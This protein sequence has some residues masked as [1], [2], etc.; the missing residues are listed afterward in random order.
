MI[1]VSAEQLNVILNIL[2]QHVPGYEVRAFGSRHNWTAK[3]YSDLDLAVVGETKLDWKIISNLK[4]AFEESD[5]P[6][7]VDVLDWHAIPPKF[8]DVI[9][10]GFEVIQKRLP[11]RGRTRAEGLDVRDKG[12]KKYIF[13]DFVNINPIVK[14]NSAEQNLLGTSGRQR[15]NREAFDN[16]ELKLPPLPTQ[17][18]IA[19]ILSALDDKIELNCQT[20]QTLE[21][22]AQAIFKEWFVDFR[23]PGSTGEMQDSEL[24]P[25][26]KGWR[27]K[28]LYDTA[29]FVNGSAFR[30]IDFSSNHSGLPIIK[31]T[32]LKNGISNQTK[33]TEKACEKKYKIRNGEILFSWSGSPDTSIDTFIWTS[34]PAWLNQHIF[35]VIPHCP[36]EKDFIYHLLRFLKPIF[37]EI[38]RDKQ[39]TGLGHVTVQDMKRMQVVY[40]PDSIIHAFQITAAAFLEK[41]I[42]NSQ[43][44]AT[45]AVIRDE[46]LP[47]LINEE[48]RIETKEALL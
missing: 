23:F 3:D 11:V 33:F 12:W 32:E 18:C 1:D 47:K 15:V 41:V 4:E 27:V 14:L 17:R 7:R 2:K 22:I 28:S 42:I 29:S 44:S 35:K 10:A 25:I 38:A 9:A 19:A 20:N 40:P 8:R 45:L 30:E 24:G 43:Q 39:T 13:T 5:L 6:F 31:I 48:V 34:G 21:A 26:P 36:F 37:I 16:L 46:L